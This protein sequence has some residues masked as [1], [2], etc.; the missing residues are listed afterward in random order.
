MVKAAARKLQQ[1]ITRAALIERRRAAAPRR[2]RPAARAAPAT[3]SPAAVELRANLAVADLA[4]AAHGAQ[5]AARA[6]GVVGRV[7][8][9]LRE[10]ICLLDALPAA[11]RRRG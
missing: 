3:P 4:D 2:A 9:L 10:A 11:R 1:P 5:D 6:L 8:A 7:G